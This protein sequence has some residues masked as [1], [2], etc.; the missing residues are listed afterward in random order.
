MEITVTSR[1]DTAYWP[2]FGNAVAMTVAEVEFDIPG[3]GVT[4]MTFSHREDDPEGM[5][6]ADN[7]IGP[8]G[9]PVFVHGAGDRSCNKQIAGPQI[10]D[11]I[12]A[13]EG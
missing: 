5:W 1:Q 9:F 4:H 7:R 6:L 10:V 11:A 2:V 13:W 3:E 12:M 8:N